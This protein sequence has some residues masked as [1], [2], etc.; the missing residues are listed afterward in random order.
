[1]NVEYLQ[2]GSF[3]SVEHDWSACIRARG[4]V[5]DQGR[6]SM[7]TVLV[8]LHA[9]KQAKAGFPHNTEGLSRR[10]REG[11]D[12]SSHCCPVVEDGMNQALWH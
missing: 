2:V 12:D 8:V 5:G 4:T 7:H 10:Q 9:L 6:A 3:V 11:I 1:M